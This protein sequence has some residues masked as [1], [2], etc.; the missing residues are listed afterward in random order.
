MPTNPDDI[1]I[2]PQMK[3]ALDRTAPARAKA[4]QKA[5]ELMQFAY[6]L[7]DHIPSKAEPIADD[8]FR[9]ATELITGMPAA[10][11]VEAQYAECG[12]EPLGGDPIASA[13][14]RCDVLLDI[15]ATLVPEVAPHCERAHG[16]IHDILATTDETPPP[17]KKRSH[18]R[19]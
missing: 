9:T 2:D 13:G 5:L 8:L 17:R 1:A 19:S 15:V 7:F 14:A 4:Y 16:L 3:A 11:I 18:H 6:Q 12:C 10:A